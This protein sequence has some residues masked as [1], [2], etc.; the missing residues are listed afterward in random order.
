MHLP[1]GRDL[2]GEDLKKGLQG[3]FQV[4]TGNAKKVAPLE[5]TQVNENFNSMV[6]AKAPKN[7]HYS[8][9]ES[10]CFRASSALCKKD[11]G[12]T[13]LSK[14]YQMGG[15]DTQTTTRII[16]MRPGMRHVNETEKRKLKIATRD[17]KLRRNQLRQKENA[18]TTH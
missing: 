8:S 3:L 12:Q 15:T 4:Y 14:V 16:G 18:L 7:R 5:S 13:Y 10:L 6:A 11:I 1:Y 17:F 2:S 9:S